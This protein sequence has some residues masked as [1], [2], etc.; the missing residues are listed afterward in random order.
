MPVQDPTLSD[1]VLAAFERACQE[2]DMDVAEHLLHALEIL[3]QRDE[4]ATHLQRAYLELANSI[5][6][7]LLPP[8]STH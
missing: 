1:D 8:P 7:D 4:S 5:G 2:K 6:D 3:A